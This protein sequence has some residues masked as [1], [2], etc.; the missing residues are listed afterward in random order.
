MTHQPHE[1]EKTEFTW[2]SIEIDF[3]DNVGKTK[4]NEQIKGAVFAFLYNT[5]WSR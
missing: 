1:S 3:G 4:V 5:K 2:P